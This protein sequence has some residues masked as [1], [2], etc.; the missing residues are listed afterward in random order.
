MKASLKVFHKSIYEAYQQLGF[1]IQLSLLWLLCSIPLITIGFANSGVLYCIEHKNN[2]NSLF[3]NFF[4]GMKEYFKP[5]LLLTALYLFFVVPGILYFSILFSSENIWII[6]LSLIILYGLL[7]VHLMLIYIFPLMMKQ[8]EM[9]VSRI[10]AKTF[11]ITIENIG[12]SINV[13]IYILLVTA[14]TVI[15]PL[16]LLILAGVVGFILYYSVTHTLSTYSTSHE[17]VE[18]KV[19]WRG[20]WRP[21]RT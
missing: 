15:F 4:I 14:I 6:S 20:S 13:F 1:V 11:K 17:E 8:N 21:W 18:W 7:L 9:R 12:F 10:L 16:L 5:T 2:R 19:N 3:K